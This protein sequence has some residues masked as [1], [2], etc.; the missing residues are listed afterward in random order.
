MPVI[1]IFTTRNQAYGIKGR[2]ESTSL[3]QCYNNNNNNNHHCHESSHSSQTQ[4]SYTFGKVKQQLYADTYNTRISYPL[5]VILLAMGD[6]KAC[7]C[8]TWIHTDLTGAFGFFADDLYN[9]A[10]A[11]VFGS[12]FSAS[13]WE[14]FWR[15]SNHYPKCLPTTRILSKGKKYLD[16]I[17]WA[18][19]DPDMPITSVFAC[20]I[21]KGI[22][23]A[24]GTKKI[25]LHVFTWMMRCFWDDLNNG[26][27]QD[28]PH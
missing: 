16:M 28:L 19:L 7:F 8:F 22:F 3:L 5:T 26:Y 17:G 20:E 14:P 10:A 18:E 15:A 2:Q 27:W 21:T 1:S 6:I 11:M 13:S 25:C 23:T 24:D 12:T 9:L 4:S